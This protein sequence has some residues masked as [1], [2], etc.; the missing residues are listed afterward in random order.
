MDSTAP[1][2]KQDLFFLDD[3]LRRG[4]SFAEVAGFLCRHEGEVR[5]KARELG[6]PG[7][8]GSNPSKLCSGFTGVA[9]PVTTKSPRTYRMMVRT[10]IYPNPLPPRA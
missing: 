8:R 6:I 4:S 3:A 2:C 1:W 10:V 5:E 9:G 7:V